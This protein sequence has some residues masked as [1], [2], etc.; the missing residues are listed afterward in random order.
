MGSIWQSFKGNPLGWFLGVLLIAAVSFIIVKLLVENA[1]LRADVDTVQSSFL[2]IAT[3][4]RGL[5]GEDGE[6]AYD[7]AVRY[8]FT[9]TESEWLSSLEG[10][11][12]PSGTNGIDGR[13]GANG[14]GV[15]G[16]NGVN[17]VSVAAPVC[18]GGTQYYWYSATGS[19]LGATKA[20][21]LL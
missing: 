4:N 10:E 3:Q 6:S 5:P 21:C 18:V 20:I 11:R 17:G 1:E 14:V 16:K 7:I 19:Y 2:E 15:A 12:G 9:G 8:G 13:N